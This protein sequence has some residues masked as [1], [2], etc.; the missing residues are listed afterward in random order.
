[1]NDLTIYYVTHYLWTSQIIFNLVLIVKYIFLWKKH[2]K[3]SML[4]N[5]LLLAFGFIMTLTWGYVILMFDYVHNTRII[6]TVDW[7]LEIIITICLI[8]SNISLW[9]IANWR[10]TW[11]DDRFVLCKANFT[12]KEIYIN[13]IDTEKSVIVRDDIRDQKI[14][15]INPF[16]NFVLKD[17]TQ[18]KVIYDDMVCSNSDVR[19][20][21][22]LHL[23]LRDKMS[24]KIISRKEYKKNQK[25]K[26]N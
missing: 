11:Y 20:S 2:K 21:V 16:I 10:F 15:E 4:L 19:W 8:S 1:M 25:V 22:D 7:Y 5:P 6:G 23:L 17:G 9:L 14:F 12:K 18:V 24:L 13:D 26:N 3:D